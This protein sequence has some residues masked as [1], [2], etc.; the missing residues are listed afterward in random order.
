MQDRQN[1]FIAAFGKKESND[2]PT[3]HLGQN[4]RYNMKK[5]EELS[6]DE[7]ILIGNLEG[8]PYRELPQW[9]LD[10]GY[11]TPSHDEK[12]Y[13]R[14]AYTETGLT[15]SERN[16][17]FDAAQADAEALVAMTSSDLLRDSAVLDS[18][19][20]SLQAKY[21]EELIAMVGEI[22]PEAANYIHSRAKVKQAEALALKRRDQAA[23]DK[24]AIA[25]EIKAAQEAIAA[26]NDS[27]KGLTDDALRNELTRRASM[28]THQA[29]E[30]GE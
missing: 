22:D 18:E 10:G 24:D 9:V 12:K 20:A 25:N 14:E 16:A 13:Q 15:Q 23:T 2:V 28:S 4:W 3:P 7:K 26:Q 11:V 30:A 17:V 8:T 21:G 5:L 19:I 6:F 27:V 29:A 1:L